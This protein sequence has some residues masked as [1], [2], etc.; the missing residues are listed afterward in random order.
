MEKKGK[1]EFTPE[2]KVA[3]I[4]KEIIKVEQEA[5]SIVVKTKDDYESASKFLSTVVKP[6]LNRVYE[7]VKFFTDPFKE[8]RRV[9]LANMNSVE[10]L[11]GKQVSALEAIEKKVK[12]A[13]TGYLHEQEEIALKEEAR[14]QKIRDDANIKREEKGKEVIATPIKA[15]ERT[16]TTIK[17]VD[18][19]KTTARKM[20]M[21][22]IKSDTLLCTDQEFIKE[23]LNLAIAKGLHEQIVR[24]MVNRGVREIKGCRIYEDFNIS[25]SAGK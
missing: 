9:A 19:G 8:S 22:E 14:L 6:R 10:A 16:E 7:L 12:T 11:F 25:A 2:S 18:G 15:V 1:I 20:W 17:N 13:M 23:I 4:S 3:E 24:S 5:S 21:F